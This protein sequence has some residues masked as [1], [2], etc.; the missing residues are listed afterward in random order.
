MLKIHSIPRLIRS[1]E[2]LPENR[3]RELGDENASARLVRCGGLAGY[4]A[5]RLGYMSDL[6]E[7]ELGLIGRHPWMTH[8]ARLEN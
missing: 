5:V 1:S 8:S 4:A 3:S 7:E 2:C 6:G